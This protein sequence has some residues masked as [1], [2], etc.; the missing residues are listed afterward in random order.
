MLVAALVVIGRSQPAPSRTPAWM[1]IFI[2]T[3]GSVTFALF[4]GLI[5]IVVLSIR[6]TASGEPDNS[7]RS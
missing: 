2:G 1:P 6:R 4:S 3:V 5:V 7:P